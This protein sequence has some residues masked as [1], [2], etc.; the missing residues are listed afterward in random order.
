[1]PVIL[2]ECIRKLNKEKNIC[3]I[4]A[5]LITGGS[6]KLL[7]SHLSMLQ[8]NGYNIYLYPIRPVGKNNVLL[9]KFFDERIVIKEQPKFVE[10]FFK[11]I[12]YILFVPIYIIYASAKKLAIYKKS[13]SKE[14]ILVSIENRILFKPYT[15]LLIIRIMIDNFHCRFKLISS[16]HFSTYFVSYNLQKFLK[17]PTVYTEISSPKGR[18]NWTSK[19]KTSKYLNSFSK[20]FVP[21]MIIGNELNE[22]ENLENGFI[23]SPF[24]IEELPYV[25]RI[26]KKAKNFGLIGRLSSEKNQDLLIR[27]LKIVLKS[28]PYVNLVL[29]GSGPEELR[30]KLLVRE[31]NLEK[32]VQFIP[33]FDMITDIIDKIDIFVM[34]SEV[35]GMP[36]VLLEALYYCKP[37]VTNDVGSTSELVIDG[38]NGFIINKNNIQ[39]LAD[40][41]VNILEKPEL[42]SSL[43]A[44]SKKL[45]DNKYK[46]TD[47]LNKLVN[48]YNEL[49]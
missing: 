15:Y 4:V 24:V 6:D 37:I 17:I 33:N 30:Y 19:S 49:M 42:F 34:C 38:Y 45:Y 8:K 9:M 20:I 2:W 29:V 27:T 23:I 43:S 5:L 28:N 32:N 26:P 10:L 22:F 7:L 47:I 39:D 18:I 48:E 1:M 21:S 44:N 40:K 36:L 12:Q 11:I 13:I 25:C 3:V 46:R 16:Y 31:L 41:I 35:E 14:L